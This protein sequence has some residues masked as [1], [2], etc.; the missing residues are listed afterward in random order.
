M[1]NMRINTDLYSLF[2]LLVY[3]WVELVVGG[4]D[5]GGG[6]KNTLSVYFAFP[7]ILSIFQF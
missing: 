5:G 7:V 3:G 6:V 2:Y 1:K 4:G